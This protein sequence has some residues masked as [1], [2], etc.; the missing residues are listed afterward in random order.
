M[1]Q[2]IALLVCAH[3]STPLINCSLFSSTW[4]LWASSRWSSR[5]RSRASQPTSWWTRWRTRT[6]CTGS[7]VFRSSSRS[8]W[9]RPSPY[10]GCTA[11]GRY[12]PALLPMPRPTSLLPKPCLPPYYLSLPCYPSL[13][14]CPS[15]AFNWLSPRLTSQSCLTSLSLD[16][17]TLLLQLLGC[18]FY[19]RL[20]LYSWTWL[21]SCVQACL[22]SKS[23]FRCRF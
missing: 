4:P 22:V 13:P 14:C 15:D 2:I 11:R 19:Y 9:R 20:S 8:A 21:H 7:T 1:K 23:Q 18:Y 16:V 12:C 5:G 6:S 17:E 10:G 3:Q